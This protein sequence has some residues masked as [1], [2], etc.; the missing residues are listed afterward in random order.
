MKR[1]NEARTFQ[2]G[3]TTVTLL[4][5]YLLV[6]QGLAVGVTTIRSASGLFANAICLTS[7][8]G[9]AKNP[10]APARPS[11]H[12]D[13]CCVLQCGG[14]GAAAAASPFVGEIPPSLSYV[15]V[16]LAFDETVA[17]AETATPPLG[18]RAPPSLI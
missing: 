12:G 3:P 15:E 9:E 4:V 5:A 16:K 7:A 13:A 11:R 6:L 17:R 1:R 8:P 14:M 10:A 18:S 2:V